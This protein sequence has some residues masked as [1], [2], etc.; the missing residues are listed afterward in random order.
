MILVGA[1]QSRRPAMTS[2]SVEASL[3]SAASI[4]RVRGMTLI[5]NWGHLLGALSGSGGGGQCTVGR[6]ALRVEV[7]EPPG[8][9]SE[10][11]LPASPPPLLEPRQP[12]E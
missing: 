8:E 4:A 5:S 6:G 11:R 2:S 10:P 3:S 9:V 7:G 1:A 12:L